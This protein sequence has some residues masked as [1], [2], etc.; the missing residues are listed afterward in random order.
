MAMSTAQQRAF[1]RALVTNT[2]GFTL[3]Q[4]ALSRVDV[5]QVRAAPWLLRADCR[6]AKDKADIL[7][8]LE[9][10]VGF[11]KCNTL[12]VGLLREALVAQGRAALGR[13]TAAERRASVLL[14]NLGRLLSDMGRLEEA[15]P[16]YEEELQGCRDRL[17]DTLCGSR[18]PHTLD[19]IFDLADLLK[20]Q[21]KLVEAI[22]LYTE[23][24]EGRVLL[25]GMEHEL[26]RDVAKRLVSNLRKAGQQKKAEALADKHGLAG[27]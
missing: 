26:T 10:G 6:N 21:G 17:G 14:H 4:E 13:L 27:N 25:Y 12:V 5:R 18:H 9:K 19:S 3:V 22:P 16:L 20:D 11:D 23:A 2:Y 1:E 15:R 24:L 8:E 7:D